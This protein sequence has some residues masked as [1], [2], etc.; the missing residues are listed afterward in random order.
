VDFAQAH[1]SQVIVFEALARMSNPRR[2]GWMKR[3][4]LRRS[5]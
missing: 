1:G 3:W 2:I 5:Y 4:N